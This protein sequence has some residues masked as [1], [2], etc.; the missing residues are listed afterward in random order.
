MLQVD[1]MVSRWLGVYTDVTD[2]A[3]DAGNLTY[4]IETQKEL[5]V[6]MEP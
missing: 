4:G 1:T 5:Q 2:A 3:D 6:L